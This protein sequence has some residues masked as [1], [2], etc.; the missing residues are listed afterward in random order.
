MQDA[1]EDRRQVIMRWQFTRQ[2]REHGSTANRAAGTISDLF[3]VVSD[4]IYRLG[5]ATNSLHPLRASKYTTTRFEM[6]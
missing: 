5:A 6:G 2:M 4:L 1:E 3:F